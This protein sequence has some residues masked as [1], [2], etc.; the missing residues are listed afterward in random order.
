MTVQAEI[1]RHTRDLVKISPSG[2]FYALHFRFALPLMHYHS[3]PTDWTDRYTE[4]AYALRDPIIL[5]GF[6]NTGTARW[7]DITLPDPEDILG[8]ARNFG[9]N[10]G[11][12]VATGSIKSRTVA[13]AARADREFSRDEIDTFAGIIETMHRLAAPPGSLS[14]AQIEALALIAGGDRHTA[15]AAKL[16]ISESALKAR[17]AA[18]RSS[19]KART[20]TEAIQRARNYKLL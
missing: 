13:S 18:A 7:S 11:L 9:M 5:W 10:Y 16:G 12:V 1:A 19:L 6:G 15:A 17:L 4:R 20:T 3:Y 2:L 14:P 8:Q